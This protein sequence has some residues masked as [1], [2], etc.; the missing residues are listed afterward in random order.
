MFLVHLSG[1]Y[2]NTVFD[3]RD[4]SFTVGEGSEANIIDGVERAV[5]KMK[6]GETS[7][8]IIRPQYAFG[9]EGN[10]ELGVPPN[11][12]IEYIVTLKSFEKVNFSNLSQ[13]SPNAF[14]CF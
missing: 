2:E 7:R 6:K 12:T 13:L 3:E 1:K 14:F 9:A 4:V 5:E 11:A 10:A 8:L